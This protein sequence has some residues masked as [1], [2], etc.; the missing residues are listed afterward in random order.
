MS[1]DLVPEPVLLERVLAQRDGDPM[2]VATSGGVR[3]DG[4]LELDRAAARLL[5]KGRFR[6]TWEWIPE[7]EA[8]S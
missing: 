7:E 5:G 3:V 6:V 8:A 1:R 2:L 4:G